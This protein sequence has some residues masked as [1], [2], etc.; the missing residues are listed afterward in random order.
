MSRQLETNVPGGKLDLLIQMVLGS[1][2][3]ASISLAFM[4]PNCL[5]RMNV[6]S[7][8]ASRSPGTND[9]K[10]EHPRAHLTRETGAVGRLNVF[11]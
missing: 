10:L 5:L 3:A 4:S 9:S 7:P 6:L 11:E 2:G 1:I 8:R